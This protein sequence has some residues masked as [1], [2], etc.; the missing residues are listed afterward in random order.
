MLCFTEPQRVINL[1][2]FIKAS[3]AFTVHLIIGG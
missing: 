3:A 2:G 1:F